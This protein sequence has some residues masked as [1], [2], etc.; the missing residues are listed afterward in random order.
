MGTVESNSIT[1][2]DKL[3]NKADYIALIG[4][5]E[6]SC[7]INLASDCKIT[8]NDKQPVLMLIMYDLSLYTISAHVSL[9]MFFIR[10]LSLKLVYHQ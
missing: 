3:T 7:T 2:L 6:G 5:S 1:P 4:I 8:F 10:N 9:E